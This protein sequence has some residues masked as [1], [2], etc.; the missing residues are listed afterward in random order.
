[1]KV[2]AIIQARMG[3]TRLPG[4]VMRDLCGRSVLSHVIQ[5]VRACDKLDQVVVATTTDPIDDVLVEETCRN[6]VGCFRGSEANVLERFYLAAQQ[7]GADVVVRITSDCPLIDPKLLHDMVDSFVDA[8][9][10]S[11]ELDYMSN[12][13]ERCY[14]RGLDAEIFTF[15][16]LEYAYQHAHQAY[17]CEHVTPFIYQN[18]TLFQ[19]KNYGSE[20]DLSSHRWTLD[21]HADWQLIERI[22][23]A[24]ER[25]GDEFFT[26]DDVLKLLQQQPALVELNAH[27][28]QK[29]LSVR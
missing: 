25:I 10:D 26:T 17:E 8:A 7:A 14:P 5:R 15:A 6:N 12:T 20:R 11:T 29:E 27:V 16:A 9:N 24:L 13:L 21:T 3:S 22:Y 2:V 28:E 18:P 1:M 23:L 19:I 4:K